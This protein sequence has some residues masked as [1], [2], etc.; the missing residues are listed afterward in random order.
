[1]QGTRQKFLAGAAFPE[2]EGGGIRRCDFLDGVADTA[3]RGADANDA[4]ERHRAALLAQAPVLALKL[5]QAKCPPHDDRQHLCD[6]RLVIEVRSAK[7]HRLY[8]KL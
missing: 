3:Q 6:D 7:S 1:M 4:L 5:A 2:N 8:G